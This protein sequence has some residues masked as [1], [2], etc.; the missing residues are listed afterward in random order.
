M[1]GAGAAVV[2]AAVGAVDSA[3]EDADVDG[4]AWIRMPTSWTFRSTGEVCCSLR[5]PPNCS[6]AMLYARSN[7]CQIT[8]L[9]LRLL[10]LVVEAVVAAAEAHSMTPREDPSP[11]GAAAAAAACSSGAPIPQT[12]T[13]PDTKRRT[14]VGSAQGSA[15]ARRCPRSS[16]RTVRTSA[17]SYLCGACTRRRC[18]SRK[19]TYSRLAWRTSVRDA[20]GPR[21]LTTNVAYR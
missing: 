14:R 20:R 10:P 9:L 6:P 15:R 4:E 11:P 2:E 18:S 17:P 8:T 12:E 19:R 1:R 13:I 21:W 3:E 16:M 7:G 5:Y